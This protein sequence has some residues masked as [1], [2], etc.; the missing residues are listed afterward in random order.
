M[1]FVSCKAKEAEWSVQ[2]LSPGVQLV[3]NL[4]ILL[5]S[6]L[7]LV[8]DHVVALILYVHLYPF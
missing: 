8:G 4:V 1:G 3:L 6:L 7:S 5:G 2:K